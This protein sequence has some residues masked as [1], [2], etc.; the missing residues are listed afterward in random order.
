MS[1]R[2]SSTTFHPPCATCRTSIRQTAR[3]ARARTTPFTPFARLLTLPIPAL[4]LPLPPLPHA[5]DPG[6]QTSSLPLVGTTN[7]LNFEGVPADGYAPPDTNGSPG[8]TQYVQWV[9]A[10]FAVYNKTT[11]ALISG[12]T[13]GNTLWAGFGGPC[14]TNND[15]DIIALSAKLKNRSV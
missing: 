4:R 2:R 3:T 11:G 15:G 5:S 7:G 6:L 10:E 8:M 14:E 12:P 13:A 1:S 9:N